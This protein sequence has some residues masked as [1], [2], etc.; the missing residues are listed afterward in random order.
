MPETFEL[1]AELIR[2]GGRVANVGVHGHAA[3]L[4][5][6]KLW[7]RDVT[8]TTGLVDTVHHA[9]AA[10]ADRG[11]PPRPDAVRD[12]PVRARRHGGGLRRRSRTR[13][14]RRRSRW[15][16]PPPRWRP[17]GNPRPL[18]PRRRDERELRRA[19]VRHS[20]RR[21]AV[22]PVP[23]GAPAPLV[24]GDAEHV[25]R[26]AAELVVRTGWPPDG[27]CGCS[28][29]RAG[30]PAEL[31]RT[32]PRRARRG[33]TARAEHDRRCRAR[34]G[35][36]GYVAFDEPPALL[37][38]AGRNTAENASRGLLRVAC[39]VPWFFAPYGRFGLEVGYR[40]STAGSG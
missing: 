40:A 20:A 27:R 13:P 38:V 22:I 26:L 37:E 8:I 7:I 34:L 3:T 19:E 23:R 9:D 35:R 1:C 28:C 5:L 32:A 12:A 33:R 21:D 4:H 14:R 16:C 29:R 18:S 17:R 6:E 2:P 24:L 36:D 25:G 11:R 31:R 30:R 10:P 15:C 39:R